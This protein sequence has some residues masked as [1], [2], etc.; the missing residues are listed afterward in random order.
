MREGAIAVAAGRVVDR[1]TIGVLASVGAATIAAQRPPRV[2]VIGSGTELVDVT[3]VP[4]KGQIRDSNRHVLMALLREMGAT[5]VDGGRVG[6]DLRE[7]SRAIRAGFESDVVVISGGVSA[8]AYDLVTNAL[9]GE[10]VETMFHKVAMKPGKP[11]L[12]GRLGEKLLFGLPGNPVSTYV[13]AALFLLPVLRFLSGRQPGPWRTKA[14]LTAPLG[15]TGRRETFHPGQLLV[16]DK[17]ELSCEPLAWMGSGDQTGFSLA[18]CFIRCDANTPNLQAGL[19]V[20]IVLP[21]MPLR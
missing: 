17:G 3:D 20:D 6:D 19:S 2:T 21:Y 5:V 1:L 9:D 13:T 8:G 14:V 16:G 12:L 10:G 18:N 4:G 11:L 15:A 7:V